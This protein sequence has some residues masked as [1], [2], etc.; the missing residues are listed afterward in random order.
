M[1]DTMKANCSLRPSPAL[2]PC[3]E[4][5]PKT[6]LLSTLVTSPVVVPSAPPKRSG[7]TA[8][9][10]IGQ[11]H[12][13]TEEIDRIEYPIMLGP[14]PNAIKMATLRGTVRGAGANE[15]SRR[16]SRFGLPPWPLVFLNCARGL[17]DDGE[18]SLGSSSSSC[19]A[20][21]A[22][23]AGGSAMAT[24]AAFL[25]SKIRFGSIRGG[26]SDGGGGGGG[27]VG[28]ACMKTTSAGCE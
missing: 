20:G 7:V 26:G 1:G 27:G 2:A 8:S 11:R 3:S 9:E 15:T 23:S 18:R 22:A 17:G 25:R 4:G 12:S 14:P 21:T 13:A 28:G 16:C 10:C 6:P 5:D 24:A 19:S